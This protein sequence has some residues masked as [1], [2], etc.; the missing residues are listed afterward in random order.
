MARILKSYLLT[1][2]S[3]N[4]AL[5]L[6]SNIYEGIK[7]MVGLSDMPSP[8]PANLRQSSIAELEKNGLAHKISVGSCHRTN[9]KSHQ[10]Q[11]SNVSLD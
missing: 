11:D 3:I 4:Y 2:D 8:A 1:I 7:D 10:T 5:H 6:D 9:W